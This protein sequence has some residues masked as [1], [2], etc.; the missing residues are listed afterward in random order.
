VPRVLI[1]ELGEQRRV[2]QARLQRAD[3]HAFQLILP[4]GQAVIA[5]ALVAGRRAA[6]VLLRNLAQAAAAAAAL[7]QV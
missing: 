5:R 7:E 6:V 1:A 4:D 2:H 3:H